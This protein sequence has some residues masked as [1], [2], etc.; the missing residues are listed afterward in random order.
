MAL[1]TAQGFKPEQVKNLIEEREVLARARLSGRQYSL[2]SA[3]LVNSGHAR[4]REIMTRFDRFAGMVP[5]IDRSDWDPTSRRLQL[6]GGIWKY[7]LQAT[8]QFV[9]KTPDRWEFEV[10][11]GHF[12]GMKGAMQ[13]ET[14]GPGRTLVV[15]TGGVEGDRFPP[16]W[17]IERGAE[18][19]FAVTGRRVRSLIESQLQDLDYGR[20]KTQSEPAAGSELPRPR[21]RLDSH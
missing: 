5:Y 18:I 4:T 17:V 7:Y 11:Q 1:F 19:V 10:I 9:E 12:L 3:M 13:F 16:R 2:K 20:P 6:A 21:K 14:A 15:F 8:L